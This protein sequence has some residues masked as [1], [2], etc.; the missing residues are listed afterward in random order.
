M[1]R[2]L[3]ITTIIAMNFFAVTCNDETLVLTGRSGEFGDYYA[4]NESCKWG[5]QVDDDQVNIAVMYT[6]FIY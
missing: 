4:F 5:M 2:V 6:G 3:Y 1:S